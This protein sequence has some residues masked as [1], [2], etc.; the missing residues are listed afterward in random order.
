MR[1]SNYDLSYL[2]KKL[3][4]ISK[5]EK[6]AN[7]YRKLLT[8]EALKA[9]NAKL[10]ALMAQING[11]NKS[12]KWIRATD[13]KELLGISSSKLQSLRI[14]GTVSYSS[15]GGMYYYDYEEIIKL[16]EKNRTPCKHCK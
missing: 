7:E 3:S 12:S 8:K 16:L 14:N 4:K 11:N 13:A 10:E 9:L 2:K 5:K 1:C 6:L 15:F